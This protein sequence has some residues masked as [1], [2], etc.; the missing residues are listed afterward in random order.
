M[1]SISGQISSN[2]AIYTALRNSKK[3]GVCG[4]NQSRRTAL[5]GIESF[6]LKRCVGTGK[7]THL[8]EHDKRRGGMDWNLE[9]DLTLK[10]N[11]LSA[12]L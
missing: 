6:A 1:A 5:K 10:T 3:Q 11:G 2:P 8:D 12:S 7:L 4:L 9:Q